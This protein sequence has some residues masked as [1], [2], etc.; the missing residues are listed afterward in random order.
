MYIGKFTVSRSS[1]EAAL[2]VMGASHNHLSVD[3]MTTY[4]A[5]S[6]TDTLIGRVEEHILHCGECARAV[7][8]LVRESIRLEKPR[9]LS[10]AAPRSV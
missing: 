8:Q 10:A 1:S 2:Y 9:G 7:N 4:V 3:E 6:A 5:G